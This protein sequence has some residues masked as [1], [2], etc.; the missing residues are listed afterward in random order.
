M[1]VKFRQ[2]LKIILKNHRLRHHFDLESNSQ[3]KEKISH[4]VFG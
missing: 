1:I 2:I 3:N 4:L